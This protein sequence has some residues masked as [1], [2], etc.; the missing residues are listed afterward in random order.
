MFHNFFYRDFMRGSSK[1]LKPSP[2]KL[3]PKTVY[4]KAIPG[5][6]LSHW[7]RL[8]YFMP[9]DKARPQSGDGGWEPSP[10]KLSAVVDITVLGSCSETM[11]ISAGTIFGRI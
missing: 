1:S 4:T 8:T 11:T 9:F 7:P 6:I 2:S 5:K 10:R 3:K